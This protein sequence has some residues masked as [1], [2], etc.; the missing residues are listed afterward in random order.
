MTRQSR[1]EIPANY[2][3]TF[4]PLP[5]DQAPMFA[6]QFDYPVRPTHL[7][8][9]DFATGPNSSTTLLLQI[10]R[11]GQEWREVVPCPRPETIA[12]WR[13]SLAERARHAEAVRA[14]A[15]SASPELKSAV[16]KLVGE[17]R[18]VDA[19]KHY[20]AVTGHDL[21][22]AKDVVEILAR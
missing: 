20:R 16:R 13:A 12:A 11:D 19:I 3:W 14:L 15:A 7:I 1:H 9:I 8:Q 6:E 2:R 10:V 4:R 21:A 5:A 22:T 18:R 17:G